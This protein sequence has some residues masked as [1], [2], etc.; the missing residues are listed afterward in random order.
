MKIDE[1]DEKK[2]MYIII[3][4][5]SKF[6]I[7]KKKKIFKTKKVTKRNL[8]NLVEQSKFHWV[9]EKIKRKI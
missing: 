7:Y 4:V 3:C 8:S 1:K 9:E 5:R 2:N 6:Y